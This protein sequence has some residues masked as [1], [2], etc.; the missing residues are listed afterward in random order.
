MTQSFPIRSISL[1]SR[2]CKLETSTRPKEIP[3][4]S[5]WSMVDA[6]LVRQKN[7]IDQKNNQIVGQMWL[8][9]LSDLPL[10][11]QTCPVG[12]TLLGKTA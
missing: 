9:I 8:G 11:Y 1:D 10:F 4:D 6:H 2:S 3:P 7:K 5:R 12:P